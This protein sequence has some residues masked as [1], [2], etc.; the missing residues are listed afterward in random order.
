M[1]HLFGYKIQPS[2]QTVFLAHTL[3]CRYTSPSTCSTPCRTL[4]IMDFDCDIKIGR[5]VV[6]YFEKD[7]DG[8]AVSLLYKR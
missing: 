7:N 8:E 1:L 5:E 4:V 3:F 6:A 2:S